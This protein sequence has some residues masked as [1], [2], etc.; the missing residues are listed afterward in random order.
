M[1]QETKHLHPDQG[2]KESCHFFIS[3]AMAQIHRFVVGYYPVHRS[4]KIV[5]R[6]FDVIGSSLGLAI[7]LPLYPVIAAAIYLESPG[8]IFIRQRRAG[9]LLP[10]GSGDADG[11]G[12]SSSPRP[13][14]AEFVMMKF[15]SMRPDAEKM[16][17]PVLATQNDPRVTRTGRIL[18]KTRLDEI[19]QFLNVLRGD[20][21]IVGP[22]PERPELAE[23]LAMAIPY[24]EERMRDVK[25]GITGL[26]Q[27]SLSYSGKP[28]AGSPVSKFEA[29]LTN[30]F[31]IEGA[32]DAVADHMRVKLLYDLAYSA[33]TEDLRHFLPV[34]IGIIVRTPLVMLR[35][36]GT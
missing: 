20:M 24:F 1:I 19:P 35:A 29:D 26:A 17:G 11:T 7:T 12:R 28:H 23:Q 2:R 31:K 8:P 6:A 21:S 33:A 4:V 34:E 5:K 16:T 27:I 36:L 9:Q 32:E 30:P 22:R 18:R 13:K 10:P 25:P 14:F 3:G 15:R